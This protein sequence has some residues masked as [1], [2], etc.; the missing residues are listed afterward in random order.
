[1]RSRQAFSVFRAIRYYLAVMFGAV[2]LTLA[3]FIVLPLMQTISKP[4]ADDLMLSQ[5]DLAN[6]EPPPPPA[7]EEPEPEPEPE[8]KPPELVEQAAPLDL[9]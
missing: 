1:M 8:E 2:V 3:F 9:S 7:E 5:V 4:P 6:L